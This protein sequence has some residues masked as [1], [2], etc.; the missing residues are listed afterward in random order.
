MLINRCRIL[1]Q[2]VFDIADEIDLRE[3]ERQVQHLSRRPL[4]VRSAKQIRLS[5]PPLEMSL[6]TRPSLLAGL[7][8]SEILV[9]IY[10]V[11]ALAVTFATELAEPL[12][13]EALI[14]LASRLMTPDDPFTPAGRIIADEI[15]AGIRKACKAGKVSDV[16]E[17]YTIFRIYATEPTTDADRLTEQLDVARLLLGE[18][19]PI[20]ARER[21][22]QSHAAISYGPGELVVVDWNSALIYDP[23]PSSDL[24]DLLEMASM[25]LLELRAYDDLVGRSLA[26]LYDELGSDKTLFRSSKYG[27]LSREIM[28]LFVDVTEMTDRID[29][30][31][32]TL[33]DS[34]LARL[35]RAAVNEFDIP[36]W[37]RLLRNKLEV[38]RQINDLLVDQI[39][40]RKMFNMEMAI[41]IL[42]LFELLVG[43]A[44]IH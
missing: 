1:T 25:Q 16:A 34:W 44:Q 13:P 10:D 30:S 38:M 7:P 36:R 29:N 43:L 6:G 17:D 14:A 8:P 40:S 35:H 18:T 27:R 37:Q 41:V 24:S 42:I 20:S 3:A 9:R 2:R 26:R 15:A 39:S 28:R 31:L 11:G 4:F 5:N 32:N 19:G 12:E 23:S 21:Q 22:Q 33:G